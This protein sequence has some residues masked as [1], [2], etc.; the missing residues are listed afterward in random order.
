MFHLQKTYTMSIQHIP[1][2]GD[3]YHVHTPYTM[4]I[5]HTPSPEECPYTIYHVHKAYSISRRHVR[6]PYIM[7]E[8]HIPCPKT[9]YHVRRP[10]IMFGDHISCLQSIH[11]GS[12]YILSVPDLK[13]SSFRLFPRFIPWPSGYVWASSLILFSRFSNFQKIIFPKFIFFSICLI[14]FSSNDPTFLSNILK[15]C[16]VA[17]FRFNLND[18][19]GN[20]NMFILPCYRY[21]PF[22]F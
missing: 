7:F 8:D 15:N 18:N 3:I 2:P 5:K 4:S 1:S 10:Y 21:D 20:I 16:Q 14:Y 19:F 12:I 17:N 6:R 9:I 13:N 22:S 11:I